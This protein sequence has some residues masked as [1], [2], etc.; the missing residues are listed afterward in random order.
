M[1][2]SGEPGIGK[3]TLTLQI[4]DR[5]AVQKEKVLYITG[6]ESVE[7]VAD[8]AKRLGSKQENIELLYE[9]NLENILTTIE[10]AKPNFLVD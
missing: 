10:N 5:M 7:Q 2:L 8:R 1:L 6:E 3:S 9:N 4:T